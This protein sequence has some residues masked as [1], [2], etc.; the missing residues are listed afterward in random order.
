MILKPKRENN[1]L[2]YI[3]GYRGKLIFTSFLSLNFKIRI[4]NQYEKQY[5]EII[6]REIP[7]I[8]KYLKEIVEKLEDINNKNL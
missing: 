8:S 2:K 6:I 5:Y 1:N 3:F 7:K 4:M